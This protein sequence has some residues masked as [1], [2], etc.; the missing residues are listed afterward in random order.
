M[1]NLAVLFAV[2]FLF[3]LTSCSDVNDNSFLTNPVMEKTNPSIT[4]SLPSPV[5]PYSYLFN[6]TKVEG[7]KYLNLEEE[8]AVEFIMTEETNKFV[9]L[10]VVV[11]F[12]QE[13]S[14]KM[15]FIDK[16][17]TESFKVLGINLNQIQDI[18]VY[19]IPLGNS[20]SEAS[21]PFVNNTVMDEVL[22]NGWKVDN[23][24]V[25]VECVGIWPSSLKYVFA[26]IITKDKSFFVFLQRPWGT[27]FVIPEYGKYGVEGIRLFGYQ[28]IMEA[29]VA[30]F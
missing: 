11:T 6:F 16:I 28:T 13:I 24:S 18:T 22:V 7:L 19:G 29:T 4:G 17:G 14:P 1:K 10:F 2:L 30:Q 23:S 3:S 25:V 15:F 20:T 12:L 26:E 21:S 8:N 9:Q 5:Y 27:K